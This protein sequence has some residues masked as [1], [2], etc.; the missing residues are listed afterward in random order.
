MV[1]YHGTGREVWRVKGVQP[2]RGPGGTKVSLFRVMAG[3]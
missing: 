1:V 2:R 3:P